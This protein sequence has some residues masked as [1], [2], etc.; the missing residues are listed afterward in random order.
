[1]KSAKIVVSLT[2]VLLL[3][4]VV[5]AYY[6]TGNVSEG[7]AGA[8]MSLVNKSTENRAAV[9]IL[10]IGNGAEPRDL[11]PHIVTGVPES[12]IIGSL[13]EGLV[14]PHPQSLEP[15]P[16]AAESWTVSKDNRV[17]TFFIGENRKWSNGD[18]VTAQDFVYS[19][20]RILSPKLASEYAYMLFIVK[21]AE[22]FNKG[23]IDDFSLVG[24]EALDHLTLRVEL[25]AP[26]PY[27]LSML[28][29]FSTFPVHRKTIEKFA[30]TRHSQWTQP[31]N[32]V[33][34]GPFVLRTWELNQVIAVTRN[35]NYW[36]NDKTILEG[37]NFFPIDNETTE[38]MMFRTGKL[39]VTSTIPVEK[40]ETYK[41]N[42]PESIN[43]G[44]YLGT[45]YYRFNTNHPILKN[46]YV[47]KALVMS[48]D[49]EK[50]VKEVTKA[51]EVA[52]FSYTPPN[53][54]G[55]TS[56]TVL[57]YDVAKAKEYLRI[58]GF[59]EGKNFPRLQLLY[60]SSELHKKVAL[61]IQQMWKNNLGISI[62]LINHDWKVYLSKVRQIEYTVARAGWI[63]DYADP[64]TF[65]DMFITNGGNNST[66]WS[67]KR[68]DYLLKKASLTQG[69]DRMKLLQ[70][71]EA[72][73]LDQLPI[74]PIYHY[75][76]KSLVHPSIREWHK[77][78]LDSH[79]Y[80]YVW[81]A[82]KKL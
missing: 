42:D 37:I 38:E 36:D 9:Q 25:N 41:V 19:W 55:Y 35:D 1:M 11:D 82:E 51:G 77:N 62:D 13:L 39:H 45:Y 65:L 33:G 2:I 73:L 47:R 24:V 48:V 59:P 6:K 27:F 72:V 46:K 67:S 61:V 16:G 8:Q 26:T 80:K 22:D 74:M 75:V 53:T 12:K 20:N 66:G 4:Y 34:N 49:R 60:N 81:I 23:K 30:N 28:T 44:A 68:Y 54:A 32:F 63:G 18:P 10:N 50:I 58:A 70:T 29:H 14:T 79:P 40:I 43:I 3:I 78:I 64:N 52:A 57:T 31:G 15:E 17:Y 21:N 69:N 56:E 71:A 5:Y 7:I 76:K